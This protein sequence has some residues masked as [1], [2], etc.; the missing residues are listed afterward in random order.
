MHIFISVLESCSGNQ[1]GWRGR[2]IN[3]QNRQTNKQPSSFGHAYLFSPNKEFWIVWL[4]LSQYIIF[5]MSPMFYLQ[6]YF[7]NFQLSVFWMPNS[8]SVWVTASS[9]THL[10]YCRRLV[11]TLEVRTLQLTRSSTTMPSKW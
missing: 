6:V 11:W 9:W 2:E 8:D 4:P 5:L 10:D 1:G 3:K 7:L